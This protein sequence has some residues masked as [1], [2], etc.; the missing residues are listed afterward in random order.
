MTDLLDDELL[1]AF[2]AALTSVDAAITRVWAPGLS[3]A[4]ID[5]LTAPHGFALPEE[6]RRWWRWHNG[7]TVDV[8]PP[9]NEI[10]PRRPLLTLAESL[11]VFASDREARRQV[12]GVDHWLMPVSD[13]PFL[14]FACGGPPDAPVPV[15]AE[16][17]LDPEPA[18]A[19]IGELVKAW[20]ELIETGAFTTD[21]NGLWEW[22]FEK[23]PEAIRRLGIY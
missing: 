2:E 8:R 14:F 12:H 5:S 16:E 11:G 22:D 6:A 3:D 15:F 21:A 19:S 1:A 9:A 20:T 4:E 13:R 17:D 10:T 18:M 7:V 23:V